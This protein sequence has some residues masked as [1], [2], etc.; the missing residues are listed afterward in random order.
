[1]ARKILSG[2]T[3]I[4]ISLALH[5]F[6]TLPLVVLVASDGKIQRQIY[7]HA[8]AHF[9][10][11]DIAFIGDS[12]TEGGFVWADKIG[13]YNFNVWNY[14]KEGF[15]TEQVAKYAKRV[16]RHR[17]KYCFVMSGMNDGMTNEASVMKSYN[18]YMEILKILRE[19]KVEPVVTL[20][21]Y[22]NNEKFRKYIDEF[23]NR[24]L[25]Y[26]TSNKIT[27]ID[28]NR[29]LCNENGLKKEYNRDDL[30]LED[31]AY[32]LWGREIN[33]VLH[34]KKYI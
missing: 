14:G 33:R 4:I 18:D 27:V 5:L 28:M 31:D 1:M 23:N 21:L 3:V 13:V 7:M 34:E 25:A 16:A 9:G 6:I 2:R 26:C 24:I 8:A 12:I 17:F 11:Y 19:A 22:R 15:K 10:E 29:Y 20:T 30:H 32:D